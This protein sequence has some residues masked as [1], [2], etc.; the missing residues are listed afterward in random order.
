MLEHKIVIWF[1]NTSGLEQGGYGFLR[2]AGNGVKY[3]AKFLWIFGLIVLAAYSCFSEV[4]QTGTMLCASTRTK[5][6]L[7][8]RRLLTSSTHCIGTRRGAKSLTT[9]PMLFVLTK[10]TSTPF[11][12]PMRRWKGMESCLHSSSTSCKPLDSILRRWIVGRKQ[13]LQPIDELKCEPLSRNRK[14]RMVASR[15]F[16]TKQKQT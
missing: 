9:A 11:A 6:T 12:S 2:T 5:G 3:S 7:E 13:I 10:S 14:W 15:N 1:F 16:G 8:G 4:I